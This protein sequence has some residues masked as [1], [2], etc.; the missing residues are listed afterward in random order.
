MGLPLLRLW[1]QEEPACFG[2]LL[3]S[4]R[5]LRTGTADGLSHTSSPGA[6]AGPAVTC[7][8]PCWGFP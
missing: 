4:W 8:Q 5:A 7:L 1:P 3:A 6:P 2:V